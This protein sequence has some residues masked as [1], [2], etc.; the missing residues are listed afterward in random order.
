MKRFLFWLSRLLV[1]PFLSSAVPVTFQRVWS[2]GVGKSLIGPRGSTHQCETI[3]GIATTRIEPA[4]VHS[5][6]GLLFLHGGG[7]VLGGAVSHTQF[8]AWTGQAA[9]ARTW[10]PEDRLAPEHPSPAA[11]QDAL[12]VYAALLRDGQDPSQLVIAG[13]SAG[14][15]LALATAIAIRDG[16]LPAPAAL[17]LYS[18]WVDLSLSGATMQSRAARDGMLTPAWL[19][20]C[21]DHYRGAMRAEDPACSPLFADLRGLPPMLIH[22]G[23]EEILLADAE[24][25]AERARAAGVTVRFKRFDGVGH[26]FQCN[27]GVLKEAQ[28]SLSESAEFLDACLQPQ[29]AAA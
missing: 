1:R 9:Q 24:R 8:A 21:A 11:Q 13:D 7:Y 28:Q 10:L 15:G 22:A 17:L 6:R 18:P 4:N 12:A 20:F 2:D 16:G 29:R 27:A 26:I 23:T 19:R 3:A 25:L 14:G 5:G